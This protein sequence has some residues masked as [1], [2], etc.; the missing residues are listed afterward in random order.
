VV[1]LRAEFWLDSRSSSASKNGALLDISDEDNP[2]AFLT[3]ED[4]CD[5]LLSALWDVEEWG[6]GP[7]QL[8]AIHE[9]LTW[10]AKEDR[11]W[12]LDHSLSLV[13]N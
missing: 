6:S 4:Q 3:L 8:P 13:S 10:L 12:V 11:Q 2:E 5:R 9:I 7:I 1:G